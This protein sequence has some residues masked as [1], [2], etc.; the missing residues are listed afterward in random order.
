MT[1]LVDR[2]VHI[3]LISLICNISSVLAAVSETALPQLL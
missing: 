1:H 2:L 3:H